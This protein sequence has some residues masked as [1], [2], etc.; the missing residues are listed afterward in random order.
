MLPQRR[1][2]VYLN[3]RGCFLAYW[4]RRLRWRCHKEA[5]VSRLEVDWR[6]LCEVWVS[7]GRA[8]W[9]ARLLLVDLR[10]RTVLTYDSKSWRPLQV[11]PKIC[12]LQASGFCGARF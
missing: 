6:R 9:N 8:R 11:F 10:L 7:V 2:A 1:L 5:V 12:E 4:I 3:C